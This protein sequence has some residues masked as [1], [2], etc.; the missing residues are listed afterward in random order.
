MIDIKIINTIAIGE[1]QINHAVFKKEKNILKLINYS[2]FD[3][4]TNDMDR[5]KLIAKDI[6]SFADKDLFTYITFTTR[7]TIKEIFPIIGNPKDFKLEI[8][9]HLKQ[10]YLV[11]LTEFN[12]D[13]T[14]SNIDDYFVCYAA[15]IPK[16]ISEAIFRDLNKEGFKLI[17]AETDCDSFK[18]G[19]IRL[20][21]EEHFIHLHI[22]K[23]D[24]IFMIFKNGIL[25][26]ERQ[27]MNGLSDLIDNL[28][29]QMNIDP[30]SAEEYLMKNGLDKNKNNEENFAIISSVSDRISVQIQRTLDMYFQT[31]RGEPPTTIVLTGFGSIIP[32]FD[33]YISELFA[34]PTFRDTFFKFMETD[35][36]IDF[37]RFDFL[38]EMICLGLWE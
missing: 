5:F 32:D 33:R 17:T 8:I 18:R 37:K 19:I 14:I 22:R 20:R 35:I 16:N 1:N 31:Y 9:E 24:S 13:Y 10:T 27:V 7:D 29:L 11:D 12:F 28:S 26:L 2:Y 21:N 36:D 38:N 34:L 3:F 6:K 23:N 30:T 25:M 15:M 4:D